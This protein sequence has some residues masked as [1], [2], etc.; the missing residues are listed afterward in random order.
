MADVI[1]RQAGAAKS[2]TFTI[3]LIANPAL[4]A[5]WNSGAFIADP[6]IGNRAAFDSAVQYIEDCLF[7]RVAG[8]KELIIANPVIGPNVRVISIWDGAAGVSSASALVGQDGVSNLLIARRNQIKA[9]VAGYTAEGASFFVDVA[10]A[11]SM[12]ATHTRAS[13]WYTS[14]I[15]GAAG[16]PFTLDGAAF[17]HCFYNDILGT[18][19]IH[20]SVSDITPL[21]EFQHAISS[22]TNG[23]IT[24]LYVDSPPAFNC[25]VGR[26]IPPNFCVY[27]RATYISDPSRDGLG[28]PS[29]WNSYHCGLIDARYPAVMDNYYTASS[30]NP[31]DCQNDTVTRAFVSDKILAKMAR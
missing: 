15:P 28:Y 29:G 25:K 6:I 10:Y 11:I 22:Y 17:T 27:D 23:G 1:L 3:C 19:A 21:H 31:L 24:D 18:I 14:D 12:S 9:F 2:D 26:P 8:M 4:E 5:P 13:A 30:H 7:G 20:S 16:I